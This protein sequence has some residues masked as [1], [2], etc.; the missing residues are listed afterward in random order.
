MALVAVARPAAAQVDPLLF[1]KDLPPNVVLVVDTS[2]RMQ[3]DA[4]GTYY[5]PAEYTQRNKA[6]EATIGVTNTM[7]KYSKRWG[8]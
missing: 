1:L 6:W 5:D 2:A 7:T 4:A 8:M 3:F